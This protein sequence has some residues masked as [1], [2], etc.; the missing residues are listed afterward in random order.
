MPVE[1]LFSLGRRLVLDLDRECPGVVL[2]AP[3]L[4]LLV[5]AAV[6]VGVVLEEG[7]VSSRGGLEMG[8]EVAVGAVVGVEVV[9]VEVLAG[10]REGGREGER[11]GGREGGREKSAPESV[12]TFIM[13]RIQ[14][15]SIFVNNEVN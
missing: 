10:G 11:E 8:V 15:T 12:Y 4:L 6:L 5:S 3:P 13:Y 1:R 7:G 14:R 2:D 9:G